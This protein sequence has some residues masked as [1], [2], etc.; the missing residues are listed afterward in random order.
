MIPCLFRKRVIVK[1]ENTQLCA[2]GDTRTDSCEG[3]SGGPLQFPAVL[4]QSKYVQFGIVSYGA[5]GCGDTSVPGI[6][7]RVSSYME[8]ILDNMSS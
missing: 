5:K 2:G 1:L 3:D 6:Y 8:W 4:G 7:C